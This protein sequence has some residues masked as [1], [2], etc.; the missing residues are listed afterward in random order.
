MIEKEFKN[1]RQLEATNKVEQEVEL[2]IK[3]GDMLL[4]ADIKTYLAISGISDRVNTTYRITIVPLP[5]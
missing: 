2:K 5:F 4:L 3:L 1:M